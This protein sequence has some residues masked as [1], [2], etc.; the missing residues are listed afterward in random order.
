MKIDWLK[1]LLGHPGPFA[2]L[3]LDATPSEQAADRDVEGR[4]NSA[5]KDLA[6]Q[7]APSAVLDVLQEVVLRPTRVPGPHGRIVIADD[8]GVLVDRVVNNPPTVTTCTWAPVPALLQAALAADE[9]VEL[10]KV[11]V[12]R[13]GA[14][15]LRAGPSGKEHSTF[16]APHDEIEKSGSN[17][18]KRARIESRAEDS[19]ERNAAAVA[20]EIE[21]KVGETRPELVLLTGDVR[22]VALVRAALT[23]PT[24]ENVVE[25]SGG[26]RSGGG[27]HEGA[28]AERVGEALDSYRE[29]RRERVLAELRQELG[30]ESNAV[31]SVG[32]VVAVLSRGQVKEL[33]LA[34]EYGAGGSP[35][36]GRKL[37]IGPD[38]MHIASS[39]SELEAL[40]VTGQ[41]EE[42]PASVALVRAAVGQDAGL[43]FAPE[44]SV[45]LMD[46]VAAT[47]RWRDEGTPTE[48]IASMSGDD[49]RLR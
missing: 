13:Q 26:G 17:E 12:D 15:F 24:T 1:P 34:E 44:G 28:F 36:N 42:L 27:V 48:A 6:Q 21:R 2:T 18:V 33:V 43:T 41:L 19:W 39:R 38:P 35:M 10:L 20:A 32:D 4:W 31:T 5:R 16:Q 3:H 9:S 29:R 23:A 7:G 22:V 47:L 46:G 40:G 11:A 25:V 8:T 49:Q 30:R 14:D 45:G 37:W